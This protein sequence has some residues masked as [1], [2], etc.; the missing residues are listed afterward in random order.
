MMSA[1]VFARLSRDGGKG[2]MAVSA[3]YQMPHTVGLRGRRAPEHDDGATAELDAAACRHRL[4]VLTG[5]RHGVHDH[6]PRLAERRRRHRERHRL[7]M[8]VEEQYEAIV[9]DRSPI[10]IQFAECV[11]VEED[12]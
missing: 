10:V 6:V 7:V 8:R 5:R 1:S 11:A 4:I 2:S 12:G 3:A 9:A